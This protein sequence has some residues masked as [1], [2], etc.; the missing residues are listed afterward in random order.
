MGKIPKIVKDKNKNLKSKN[1]RHED[2]TIVY[3]GSDS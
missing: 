1:Q 3:I 2:S